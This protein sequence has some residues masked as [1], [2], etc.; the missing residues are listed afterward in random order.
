MMRYI[1]PILLLLLLAGCAELPEGNY[2]AFPGTA[3][4]NQTVVATIEYGNYHVD[5]ADSAPLVST[6]TPYPTYTP[7]VND[8]AP[9][10]DVIP[11]TPATLPTLVKVCELRVGDVNHLVRSDH[12]PDATVKGTILAKT[13]VQGMS[14][15]YSATSEEWAQIK[16]TDNITGN[17][18]T[19]W[20]RV[21]SN[22]TYDP[23]G[24]C[25]DLPSEFENPLPSSPTPVPTQVGPTPTP[26]PTETPTS[27]LITAPAAPNYINVRVLPQTGAAIIGQFTDRAAT[28]P[29]GRYMDASKLTWYRVWWFPK[30]QYAWVAR[31]S[32]MTV[33]GNCDA[34]PVEAPFE[35]SPAIMRGTHNLMGD[36][37]QAVFA[38]AGKM[39][40]AKCLTGSFDICLELKR[41]N[42]NIYLIARSL[43]TDYGMID[44]PQDW[45]WGDPGAWWVHVRDHLPNGFDAYEIQ[46]E[47]GPPPQGYG[48]W[49]QWSIEIAKMV[50]RDKGGILLAF[51]FAAGNPDYPFWRELAPY[52]Q[53]VDQHGRATGVWHGI[54]LHQ[55]LYAP[56]SRSD[57]PWLNNL[58]VAGRHMLIRDLLIQHAGVDIANWKGVIL[59]TEG[60]LSDGYSGNWKAPYTCQELAQA[61]TESAR[62]W[63]E[64]G[65][66]DGITLWNVGKISI[67]TSDHLCLYLLFP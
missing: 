59:I 9:T 62:R 31:V 10:P 47:C 14:F 61:F 12:K 25:I 11:G 41:R 35:V 54:A 16:G 4:P 46:N 45:N 44:C 24:P 58:H 37:V 8:P 49:A 7:P 13:W 30:A 28:I 64:Q 3:A 20:I 57:M 1:V 5:V 67:W 17:P 53:W 55:S 22:V 21:N 39:E 36:G 66:V 15:W 18:I 32:T 2:V 51:S 27:C 26:T 6:S 29:V 50:E 38:Y 56:W 23:L 60:G 48:H 34:L 43:H 42:P 65:V 63:K 52:I 40:V 19:G 33:Q